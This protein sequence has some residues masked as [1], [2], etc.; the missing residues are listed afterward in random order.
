MKV[1]EELGIFPKDMSSYVHPVYID[2]VTELEACWDRFFQQGFLYL[3]V[4]GKI[5]IP[6]FHS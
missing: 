6:V 2:L 1:L 3:V 5:R 4:L